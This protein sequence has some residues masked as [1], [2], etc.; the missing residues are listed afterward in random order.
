MDSIG[1]RQTIANVAITLANTEYS[2]ALPDG[3]TRFSIKLRNPGIAL[4][5]CFVSTGSGTLYK[6]L[7]Q[8]Q[9]YSETNIKGTG[10]TLYFQSAT[11]GQVAEIISW[12]S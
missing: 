9:T 11:L 7:A 6:N 10:N 1:A 5:I 3:T 2:Y 4:K 8:G 12:V